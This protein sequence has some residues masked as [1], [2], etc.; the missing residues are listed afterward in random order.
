MQD[1]Q[2]LNAG[3][4]PMPVSSDQSHASLGNDPDIIG[5]GLKALAQAMQTAEVQTAIGAFQSDFEF[6]RSCITRLGRLSRL[7][8][9]M[10]DLDVQKRLI[11]AGVEQLDAGH[12]VW[13]SARPLI[14]QAAATGAQIVDAQ[15]EL[16]NG[17]ITPLWVERLQSA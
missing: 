5:N 6:A 7:Q 15:A 17:S 3:E 11:A 14:A 1:G 9:L 2:S 8:S 4:L 13:E 12:D 16:L 10:Q